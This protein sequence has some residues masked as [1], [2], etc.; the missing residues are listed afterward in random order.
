LPCIEKSYATCAPPFT[1][2]NGFVTAI[3]LGTTRKLF[4]AARYE[5]T[6]RNFRKHPNQQSMQS[7]LRDLAIDL[8]I[9]W[10]IFQDKEITLFSC[11]TLISKT[12]M[13]LP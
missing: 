13:G 2:K 12:G 3:K 6:E 1:E 8:V 7:S 9:D 11:F 10:F 5:D 4:V